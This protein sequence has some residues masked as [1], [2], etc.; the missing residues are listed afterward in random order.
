MQ[1]E[2]VSGRSLLLA[3]PERPVAIDGADLAPER[4]LLHLLNA[5]GEFRLPV[6]LA[7]RRPPA[8]WPTAL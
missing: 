8:R 4:P 5:A 3:P 2:V 6:L 7:A 1:G